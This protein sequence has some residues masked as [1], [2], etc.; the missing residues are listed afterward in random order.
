MKEQIDLLTYTKGMR[1]KLDVDKY[2]WEQTVYTSP[3]TSGVEVQYCYGSPFE[4]NNPVYSRCIDPKFT[5]EDGM[6]LIE[7]GVIPSPVPCQLT[8]EGNSITYLGYGGDWGEDGYFFEYNLDTKQWT[9]IEK[10]ISRINGHVKDIETGFPLSGALV[11]YNSN[12]VYT[13]ELGYYEFT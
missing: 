12:E 6:C 3:P 1:I 4:L 10:A 11:K 5:N 8:I 13:D 9:K 2:R 7:G